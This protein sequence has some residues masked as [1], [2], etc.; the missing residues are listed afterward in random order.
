MVQGDR[1]QDVVRV[2]FSVFS[3][4]ADCIH[5]PILLTTATTM[6]E[7]LRE[8]IR[9]TRAGAPGTCF[10]NAIYTIL[11][12]STGLYTYYSLQCRQ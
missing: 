6:A 4:Y 5:S 7:R 9:E 12:I 10:L 2:F 1:A 11:M 8:G 3:F